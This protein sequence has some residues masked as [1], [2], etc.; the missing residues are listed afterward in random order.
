V[1]ANLP[2]AAA[3]IQSVVNNVTA[4]TTKTNAPKLVSLNQ[5]PVRNT[6]PTFMRMIMDSTRVV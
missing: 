4:P 2:M 3:P 5:I 1:A 6:E